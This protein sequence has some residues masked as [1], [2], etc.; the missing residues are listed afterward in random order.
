M[1]ILSCQGSNGSHA[2][3]AQGR[4]RFYIRL[5]ASTTTAI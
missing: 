5:N 2:E 1:R 4:A 3:G